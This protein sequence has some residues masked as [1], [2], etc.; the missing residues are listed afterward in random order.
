ML[1]SLFMHALAPLVGYYVVEANSSRRK[2]R[3]KL[4]K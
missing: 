3:V 2:K 4:A 1:T